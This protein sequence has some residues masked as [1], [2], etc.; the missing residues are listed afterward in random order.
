MLSIVVGF[1]V[2]QGSLVRSQVVSPTVHVAEIKGVINPL[3][4]DYVARAVREA[5]EGG[6]A[7]LILQIDTPGGLDTAMRAMVQTILGS[8]VPVIAFVAPSGA[9]AASAG[10]FVSLSAHLAAMAPGTNIG[11]AHPV[12]LQGPSDPVMNEKVLADSSAYIRSLAEMRGRNRDWVERAV[13]E[14]VSASSEEALALGIVDLQAADLADLLK[15]VDG[16]QV[17]TAYGGVTLHTLGAEII[18]RPMN[19][20]EQ[21]LQVITEPN[22]ALALITIGTLGILAEFYRPGAWFPGITGVI[23]LLLAW[24]ALGSLPT[25]WAGVALLMFAAVLL[26]AEAQSP[27]VGAFATGALASFILGALLLF[28]PVG[29][30]SLGAAAIQV[31]P[32]FVG[33][34]GAAMTGITL[35]LLWAFA[36]SSAQPSRFGQPTLVG[37]VAKVVRDLNPKG[38]IRLDGEDWTARSNGTDIAAGAA[39]RVVAIEGLVL[40][41]EDAGP[42]AVLL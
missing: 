42:A 12:S 31:S 33:I 25:N 32:L 20:A 27:G 24:M 16:R 28:R 17:S 10:L 19:P 11:A 36:R 1:A 14:S 29:T 39:V 26:V 21:I 4:A 22:I 7:A 40:I 6:A 34:V 9:R 37:S 8:R 13:R 30:P 18:H 3:T 5:E 38:V 41:V 23:S 2:L 35:G 15:K